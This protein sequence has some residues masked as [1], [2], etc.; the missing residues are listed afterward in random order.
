MKKSQ[1]IIVFSSVYVIISALWQNHTISIDNKVSSL[2][3][4]KQ[5]VDQLKAENV[6]LKIELNNIKKFIDRED[7][8][9]LKKCITIYGIPF[10]Q[11]ENLKLVI[12][13]VCHY[14]GVNYTDNCVTSIFRFK[15]KNKQFTKTIS[16]KFK[17]VEF[18]NTFMKKWKAK[19]EDIDLCKI[20]LDSVY[21]VNVKFF[22]NEAMTAKNRKLFLA[23]RE[24]HKKKFFAFLWF[25]NGRILCRQHEGASVEEI[26]S[27]E[28]LQ[29]L[30][31]PPVLE[32]HTDSD[33]FNHA[34]PDYQNTASK[35]MKT[36]EPSPS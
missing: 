36:D 19:R 9:K 25:R 4:L 23:A 34:D 12:K 16:I 10:V 20:L 11:N 15:N 5:E 3:N 21:G 28:D 30:S 24:L 2:M 22:I 18:K 17:D 32:Y 33:E 7:Q 14:I 26:H 35:R 27:E 6:S 13:N 29:L 1:K 31:I 8:R